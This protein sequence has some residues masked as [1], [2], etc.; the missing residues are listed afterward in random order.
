MQKKLSFTQREKLKFF[1][2][3]STK[4]LKIKLPP[5]QINLSSLEYGKNYVKNSIILSV[6]SSKSTDYAC[7]EIHSE[8]RPGSFLSY[9]KTQTKQKMRGNSELFKRRSKIKL[10]FPKTSESNK[11]VR[12]DTIRENY[13][14]YNLQPKYFNKD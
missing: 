9:F 13:F 6:L 11:Q 1:D 7:S 2:P 12:S 3:C 14:T 5:R 8:L 10:S 4:R